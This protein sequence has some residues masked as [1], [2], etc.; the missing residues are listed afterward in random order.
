MF[1]SRDCPQDQILRWL[2]AAD[3][4]DNNVDI[5]ILD[6][7]GR[8]VRENALGQLQPTITFE[9][10]HCNLRHFDWYAHTMPDQVRIL[11]KNA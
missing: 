10:A 1:A 11:L 3:Q 2:V 4:L 8:I 9:I 7:A 6:D 5:R